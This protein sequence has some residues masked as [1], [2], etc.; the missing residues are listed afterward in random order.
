RVN[1][2]VP[3]FTERFHYSTVPLRFGDGGSLPAVI[4]D[5]IAR[6]S[7]RA[8]VRWDDLEPKYAQVRA[9][10]DANADAQTTPDVTDLAVPLEV[11]SMFGPDAHVAY[12][13]SC[14]RF[15]R[16]PDYFE[17]TRSWLEDYW[18]SYFFTHFARDRHGYRPEA[19]L[20]K[21]YNTFTSTG[22]VYKHM[23]H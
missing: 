19:A 22:M 5:G 21:A 6:L 17:M 9:R 1:T 8:L 10:L 18:N 4:D 7:Q 11:P 13:L 23:L 15:D 14:N 20:S 2:A 12:V 3:S 16:G